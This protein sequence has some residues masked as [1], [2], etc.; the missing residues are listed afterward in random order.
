M[1][2]IGNKPIEIPP[3][4]KVRL[5]PGAIH[6]EGP[7]GKLTTGFPA[8]IQIEQRDAQ[9]V[10]RRQSDADAHLHGLARTLVQNAITGVS[11]GFSRELDIVGI[12]YRASV[13]GRVV[14]F[15]LGYSHPIDVLMPDGVIIAVEK[16]THITVSG[17][18]RYQVGQTAANIRS[19]RPPDPYKNKGVRYT[20]EVLKKKAG[21]T[22]GA[23]T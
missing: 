19:L 12:G 3:G 11:Q 16:Q 20:G 21:K 14:T 9:L 15:V 4:V 22:T 1:S 10:A 7:K 5:E 8:A 6:A 17:A 23:K 13:A 2:R 18:D